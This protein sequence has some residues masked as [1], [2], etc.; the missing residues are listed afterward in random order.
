MHHLG[1]YISFFMETFNINP[2]KKKIN[3]IQSHKTLDIFEYK[4][5]K[6]HS[7]SDD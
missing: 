4:I 7:P 3:R 6:C 5:C 1:L 2:K